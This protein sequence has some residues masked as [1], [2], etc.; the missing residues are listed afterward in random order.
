MATVN[1]PSFRFATNVFDTDGTDKVYDISF[2]L[3]YIDGEYVVAMSG[4]ED[5]D[6]KL[7]TDMQAHVVS[8]IDTPPGNRVKV[9]PVPKAG[10]KLMIF[11]QT[12]IS[13]LLVKFQDGKLQTGRNL[14]LNST[15]L[16]MAI[17]EI[18]DGLRNN[19]LIVEQ[20]IGTVVD[21]NKIITEIYKEVLELL[22]AGGIVSVAPRVW[23]GKYDPD[24]D[25]QTDF[26]IPGADVKD[27]GFYDTYV[28]GVGLE[29][30]K[31]YVVILPTDDDPRSI[32]R[33]TQ[34]MKPGWS[35]FTVL[36]GYAKP[37]TGPAPITTLA[38]PIKTYDGTTLFLDKASEFALV[39]CMN[40]NPITAT[41]K[42]IPSTGDQLV[43]GSWINI[44]ARGAGQV[45]LKG[46]PGV[47]LAVPAGL[48]A[49]AR[50]RNSVITL[51]CEDAD[52]NVWLVSGDLA[53]ED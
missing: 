20:Q 16:I 48:K 38:F 46:D 24:E 44:A 11:R 47:T 32:I 18:V 33:F 30:D 40:D 13:K 42:L 37:Y 21:L 15:Q 50:A 1:D 26:E 49:A 28:N 51:T 34:P 43:S 52:T 4:V 19:N 25:E 39:R 6:T 8:F 9:S 45:T 36:R 41:V 14:D 27:A 17:Q 5:P 23:S 7:L 22:A 29:P 10:R 31:D 35:W 53:L 2:E 3:G 12:D